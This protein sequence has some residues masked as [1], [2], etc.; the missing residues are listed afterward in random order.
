M[1]QQEMINAT[2]A[3]CMHDSTR[4]DQSE[5]AAILQVEYHL[6]MPQAFIH[7][8]TVEECEHTHAAYVDACLGWHS[9]LALQ[10]NEAVNVCNVDMAL[11]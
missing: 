9:Q 4:D 3:A 10:G 8:S 6:H 5:G 11:Y 7:H 2:T 1:I